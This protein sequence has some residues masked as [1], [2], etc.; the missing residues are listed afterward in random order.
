[1]VKLGFG[2]KGGQRDEHER[3]T[4]LNLSTSPETNMS[5]VAWGVE[6]VLTPREPRHS[7]PGTLMAFQSVNLDSAGSDGCSM[8]AFPRQLALPATHDNTVRSLPCHL[9]ADFEV[10]GDPGRPHERVPV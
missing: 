2:K 5:H 9:S 1:M 10:T 7:K 6:P 8:L 4:Y 3:N